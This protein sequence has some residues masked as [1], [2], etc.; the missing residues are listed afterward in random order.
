MN[1]YELMYIIPAK[2]T[3]DELKP[4]QKKF[5]DLIA[6]K[7]G[8]M[9]FEGFVGRRKLAYPIKKMHHGF[10][11]VNEFQMTPQSAAEVNQELKHSPDILRHL[12]NKRDAR[13]PAEA[14]AAFKKLLAPATPTAETEER[15]APRFAAGAVTAAPKARPIAIKPSAKEIDAIVAK[16]ID[17]P[18]SPPVPGRSGESA[19][20]DGKTEQS[21]IDIDKKLDELLNKDV[22]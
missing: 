15:E 7:G 5:N 12:L 17:E 22:L 9:V 21:L 16:T 10:Y 4:L 2:Y 8:E 13:T 18:P 19:N 14:E 6:A 20:E 11:L 1:Y 3:E